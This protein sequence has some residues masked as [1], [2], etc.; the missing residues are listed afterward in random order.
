M[1]SRVTHFIAA[2]L[3]A[4]NTFAQTEVPPAAAAPKNFTLPPVTRLTLPNGL[5][6]R[7][8]E[9]GNVPKV[10]IRVTTMAGNVNEAENETWLSDLTGRMM[11]EGTATRSAQQVATEAANMGGEL[12]VVT[13]LNATQVQS[14]ALSEYAP[15][16]VALLA[17]IVRNP[18]LPEAELARLKGDLARGLSIA[19][20]QPQQ[21]AAERFARAIYPNHPYGRLFPTETGLA[22][23]TINQVRGFHERNFNA[24]RTIV[25]VAGKMSSTEMEKAIR[26]AF[27]DW[28]GGIPFTA[29]PGAAN[30]TPGLFVIDRPAAV[31]STIYIGQPVAIPTSGDWVAQ[32]VMNTLLGGY[33]SSRITANI[34]EAKGYTYSPGSQVQTRQQAAAWLE[35]ADV[36]TNVTG[37]ALKE[38]LFEIDRLQNE[39]PPAEELKAVQSY[40]AGTFI[41]QNSTRAGII[42]QLSFV[43]MHG[44]G[45]DYLA[46]YVERVYAVTPADVQRAAK[47]YL[48]RGRMTI[49]VAGD[50][51]AIDEQLVPYGPIL[52]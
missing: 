49:V 25:Y 52:Q 1:N 15:R 2:M 50:R 28:K 8:V 16:M 13:T 37:P 35:T 14:D 3:F 26:T 42:G 45:D 47:K 11:Q 51:K 34:R 4:A 21:I 41:L 40:I 7:L 18:N 31:Q 10:T 6:V 22:A 5:Q 43:D 20:S 32:Q 29:A 9:Y 30:A 36:T 19:R 23:L 17:D 38:I 48:D 27:G 44:L 24:A 39:L 46:R 12:S 33:F